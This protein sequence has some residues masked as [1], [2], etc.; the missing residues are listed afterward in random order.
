MRLEGWNHIPEGFG[1]TFDRRSAPFWLRALT[2]TPFLDRYGYAL[3][4]HR[5]HGYLTPHPNVVPDPGVIV[6]ATNAGWNID[7]HA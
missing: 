1:A 4:V 3:M 2:R 6:E 7:L 5:G